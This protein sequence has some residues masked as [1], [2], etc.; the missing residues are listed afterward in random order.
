MRASRGEGA[1]SDYSD[2]YC[3]EKKE[4]KKNI[5]RLGWVFFLFFVP[6]F[7][8]LSFFRSCLS[9]CDFHFFVFFL[10]FKFSKY[11]LFILRWADVTRNFLVLN[12]IVR[13]RCNYILCFVFFF[14]FWEDVHFFLFIFLFKSFVLKTDLITC[15]YAFFVLFLCVV[16]G[17]KIIIIILLFFF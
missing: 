14:F 4:I 12:L 1:G 11:I 13:W 17:G 8:L 7:F 3:K 16:R 9:V 2:L 6:F 10:L 15:N 5:Q